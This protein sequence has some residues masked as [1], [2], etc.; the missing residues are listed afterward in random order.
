[1]GIDS[2][3]ARAAQ[4]ARAAQVEI[5]TVTD[6][7]NFRRSLHELTGQSPHAASEPATAASHDEDDEHHH[8]AGGDPHV[9]LD[10][11]FMQNFAA[12]IARELARLDPPHA[13][14][15][16]SR[17]SAYIGQLDAL[18]KEY[19][20]QLAPL[21]GKRFVTFHQAFNYVAMRYGM[22]ELSLMDADAAGF[23][24]R[25]RQELIEAMKLHNVKAVFAEPQFPIEKLQAL[26]N[27]ANARI[28]R[29]DPLGNPSV[30]EY[31]SYLA[32]MR[33]NLR[34]LVETMKE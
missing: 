22:E 27:D 29:L 15:Y 1:M 25:Q 17:A 33:T 7:P 6:D 5:L 3:A 28:G 10:P 8:H 14:E 30:V 24:P 13:D 12:C 18:D 32:M 9:W 34:A 19:R 4:T 21:K 16:R 11:V 31:S 2:W 26:A 20:S 23:G